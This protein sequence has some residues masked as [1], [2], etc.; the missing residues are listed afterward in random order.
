MSVHDP[1]RSSTRNPLVLLGTVWLV[2][3]LLA[4]GS[5]ARAL[6][7]QVGDL[8]GSFDTTLSLGAAWRVEKRDPSLIGI[9]NGGTARSVNSDDGDLNYSRGFVS[10]A[11]K[12]THDLEL[13]YR[14][15]GAFVRGSYFYDYENAEG[16][17][18]RRPLSEEAKDLVARDARF[19]DAYV[20]GDFEPA[21]RPVNLRAGWQVVSW[22]E[23][24][25]IGNSI[26]VINPV[27]V[28]KLRV[29]GSELREAL[30]PVNM[31]WGSFG[32]AKSLTLEAFYQ[33]E[34]EN[35]EADPPGTYFST[36][37]FAGKGGRFVLTGFGG[38]P[39]AACPGAPQCVPR[40]P[41]REPN[42]SGQYGVA[43]RWLAPFFD[44]E[45]GLFFINYHSR[46]PAISARAV[47]TILP[48]PPLTP[49]PSTGRYFLEYPD[50]IRLFG[51]SFNTILG[52]T[53]IALQGEYSFRQRMPLQVDDVEL[54]LSALCSPA[55]QLGACP[56]GLGGEI[57]GFRRRDVSQAQV[58]ATKVF[59]PTFGADQWTLVG[60]VGATMV[61]E[62]PDKASLR[63]EGPG[64][65]LPG[66]AAGAAA[67]GVP[68]QMDGF[69]DAFS[70][71]YRLVT[72]LDYNNAIGPV[73]LIP[74]LAFAHDVNGTSPSP[75]GNFVEGRRALTFGL[76][77]NY[78]NR[79]TADVSYT[80]F[81]GAGDF[82]LLHDRDFVSFNVKYSF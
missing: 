34:W 7:F 76:E 40:A 75:G 39:D 51:V 2:V 74:R 57:S 53:G 10:N 49:V 78:Q 18:A 4:A 63:F 82:N 60:E 15:F 21:G 81:F 9:A 30:L 1:H 67:S 62:M 25:F 37:D 66:S 44:T 43:L 31:V 69:A 68:Q 70:W 73:A 79:W 35:T 45:F 41:D 29:P 14:N 50:D 24:T 71:G 33:F 8:R 27:D 77:G 19:L 32:L 42:N 48:G 16:D 59:G 64:T 12:G 61:H 58:T 20:R 54:L 28:A 36:N 11:A 65:N 13:S 56:N 55:S 17:R 5:P 38:V 6:E 52:A 3:V 80:L 23:S 22:G 46:L 26:N 72:R 47:T